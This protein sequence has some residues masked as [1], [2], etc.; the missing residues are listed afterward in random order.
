MCLVEITGSAKPMVACCTPINNE[1]KVFTQTPLILESREFILEFL[2]VNHPLDCPICDQAGECD[3]QDLSFVWGSDTSAYTSIGFK[4]SILNKNLGLFIKTHMNRC[5]YCTRCIRYSYELNNT[6]TFNMLGRGGY[7]EIGTYVD[8]TFSNNSYVQGNVVDLCPVGAL[9]SRPNRSSTRVWEFNTINTIDILDSL[10][11][12]IR[13]DVRNNVVERI[14]PH[15]NDHLNEDWIS[16]KIRFCYD[17]FKKQRLCLPLYKKN[18]NF[19]NNSWFSIFSKI[20]NHYYKLYTKSL[21]TNFISFYTGNL[22]DV[23]TLHLLKT[24]CLHF[25]FTSLNLNLNLNLDLK[26]NFL[27]NTNISNFEFHNLF[28]ILGS[29]PKIDSPILNMKIKNLS[30]KYNKKKLIGYIGSRILINYSLKHIGIGSKSFLYLMRGKSFFCKI[31]TKFHNILCILAHNSTSSFFYSFN[32]LSHQLKKQYFILNYLSLFSSDVNVL[33]LGLSSYYYSKSNYIVNNDKSFT[34][35]LG[36]DFKNMSLVKNTYVV[37][38]GHHGDIGGLSA[39]VLLPSNLF[40]ENTS[41]YYNCEG[42]L[43]MSNII[44]NKINKIRNDCNILYNFFIFIFLFKSKER[45]NYILNI[46]TS[47]FYKIPHFFKKQ[48]LNILLHVDCLS[49][50][51]WFKKYIF[52]IKSLFYSMDVISKNSFYLSKFKLDLSNFYG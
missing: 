13:I 38:Q 3:L 22:L 47:F 32:T 40:I 36:V 34:Y 10:C 51:F 41:F 46:I 29:N 35:L 2:L 12:N 8:N 31:I 24:A 15:L 27:F 7:S 18:N 25:G 4:K 33:S 23:H 49:S 1:M 48:H 39:D 19:I 44:S 20:K 17:G 5:I 43:F 16:D 26:Q 11:S 52:T 37:Y 45:F 14:L 21:N 50:D 30:F 6:Y 42:R 9:T 28:F